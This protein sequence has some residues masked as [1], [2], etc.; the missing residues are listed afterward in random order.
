MIKQDDDFH[1]NSII[2]IYNCPNV[3]DSKEINSEEDAKVALQAWEASAETFRT[4]V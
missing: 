3:T 1:K 4:I 2:S